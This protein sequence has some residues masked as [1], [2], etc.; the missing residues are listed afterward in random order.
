ME[1]FFDKI[2]S[3]F[4]LI[5]SLLAAAVGSIQVF[6]IFRRQ[7]KEV[8]EVSTLIE[9]I[10][11]T[12]KEEG[13]NE[14]RTEKEKREIEEEKYALFL[15]YHSQGGLSQLKIS[16]WFSLIFA[17]IGF[18]VI[19]NEILSIQK[20]VAVWNQGKAFISLISGTIID[21]ISALFFVQSNKARQLMID[22]FDNLRT[23]RKFEESLKLSEQ[24]PD[25]NLKSKIKILLAL[26]FAEVKV[27]DNILTLMFNGIESNLNS[28]GEPIK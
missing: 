17:S 14:K 6:S 12:T 7:K 11:K 21:A 15:Q 23:D 20:D 9:K 19:I 4:P 5:L 24:I 1:N 3:V 18:A 8:E 28:K 25:V 22:F 13:N 2:S 27:S 16:F 26:N 10:R